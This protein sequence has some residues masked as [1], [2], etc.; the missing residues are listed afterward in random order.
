MDE[1]NAEDYFRGKT[2][3]QKLFQQARRSFRQYE[4]LTGMMKLD[5]LSDDELAQLAAFLSVPAFSLKEKR[6]VSWS[7]FVQA[8]AASRFGSEPLVGVMERVL[9]TPF[10][11]RSEI[12]KK[13]LNHE[14][15]FQSVIRSDFPALSFL[16]DRD[17]AAPLYDWYK[18]DEKAALEGFAVINRALGELPDQPMRLPYFSHRISGNPHTLDI[19][20]RTGNVFLHVLQ[21]KRREQPNLSGSRTEL[22]NDLL[23]SFHL[24]RDDVMN[25]V[26]VNGLIAEKDGAVHPMWQAAVDLRVSWN[27]P[28]RHLLELDTVHPLKGK[29]V[30]LLENSGVFSTFLEARPDLA[31]VCTNGQFRL[32]V[33]IL[34]EKLAA[35]GCTLHY[36]GDFDPEGLQMADQ[37]MSRFDGQVQ[38]WGMDTAHYLASSPSVPISHQR[39]LKLNTIKSEQLDPLIRQIRSTKR[40]GYQEGITQLL[41][42][43]VRD[44]EGTHTI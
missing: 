14:E 3:Y 20:S 16:L 31:L 2:F 24:V 29:D 26:A 1:L 7:R 8:Y 30:Y 21:M 32:A 41:L 10:Q 11:T 4:K 15:R 39:L 23:L 34:L 18:D 6:R 5:G 38:L 13:R 25:F 28:L 35:A 37:V 17:A 27:V 9:G 43:E 33:W 12:R 22:Y 19:G 36:S 40:A 42:D 44:G